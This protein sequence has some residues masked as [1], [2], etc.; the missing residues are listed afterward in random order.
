MQKYSIK[1][2]LNIQGYKIINIEEK[3][4]EKG[5]YIRIEPYKRKK[6]ICSFCGQQHKKGYSYKTESKVRDLD[7]SGNKVYLMITKRHYK[8]PVDNRIHVERIEWLKP[9]SRV[10][11]R[12]AYRTYQLTSITT[13]KEAGWYLGKDDEAI[14]RIDKGI[15]S[16]LAKK[17]LEPPPAGKNISVDEV[18]YRKY[19]RYLTNVVDADERKVI[20]ND[21]GRKAK[22]LD[23]Y[24]E[25]IG[26]ESCKKI[27]TVA[28]DGARTYISSTTKHAVNAKIVYDKFHIIQKLNNTVD[29]VRL[30]ELNK[31]RKENNTELI[32]LT[33]C[34]QRF[35]LFKNKNKMTKN[36]KQYL[37]QLCE[38]N[39]PIYEAMLLK[40]S[41]LQI[42]SYT[43]IRDAIHHF[44]KWIRETEKSELEAF[45][46]LAKSFRSKFKYIMNWFKRKVSSAISEG[47][48]NKIKRL[49]RMA[50]GYKDIEY[51]KLKIHQHCGLLKPEKPY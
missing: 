40:E 24:Y 44:V 11:K 31:A 45:K 4:I 3:K 26:E 43:K 21:K 28:L 9:W 5:L 37:E 18:S 20:W 12:F 13:N 46:H 8:C 39:K 25:A 42:Y 41:F 7:I 27:E 16:E 49:K 10:T 6:A 34:K 14:Y 22:I 2:I 19:H 48:N 36:Q 29:A 17:R 33:N 15:L 30:L 51:F 23:R 32:K 1:K 50:Y 47:I 38:I 35:I